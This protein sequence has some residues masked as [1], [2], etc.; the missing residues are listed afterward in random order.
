MNLKNMGYKMTM[1]NL[2]RKISKNNLKIYMAIVMIITSKN[3]RINKIEVTA[4]NKLIN[5]N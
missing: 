2:K 5:Y 3:Y 1:N 4:I